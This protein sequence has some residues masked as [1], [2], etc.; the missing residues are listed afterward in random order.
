MQVGTPIATSSVGSEGMFDEII[1]GIS[2]DDENRF[3]D[4]TIELYQNEN[5]W[6]NAQANGFEILSEKFEKSLF[7]KEFNQ[8][9]IQLQT[10]LRQRR[11]QNFI[12]QILKH[13]S[14]NAL[15]YMSL[16]IRSE[17]RRVGKEC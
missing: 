4:N 3:V 9:I 7:E 11:K 8:K 16:W 2:E 5:L 12:G 6:Q 14:V 10:N 17:E 1:P 15:K 13:N